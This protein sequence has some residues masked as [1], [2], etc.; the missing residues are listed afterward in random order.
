MTKD[1]HCTI[2]NSY[3]KVMNFNEIMIWIKK[4]LHVF[5]LSSGEF[6]KCSCA[7]CETTK[8]DKTH[9]QSD[10]DELF[11]SPG[12]LVAAAMSTPR[13]GLAEG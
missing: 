8:S 13:P 4:I 3:N 10:G 2:K 11:N 1:S 7:L 9:S 6:T 5:S 12:K